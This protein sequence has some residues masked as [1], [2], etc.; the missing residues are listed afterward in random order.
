[1]ARK[2]TEVFAFTW[3]LHF[4]P[5]WEKNKNRVFPENPFYGAGRGERII[6]CMNLADS[7]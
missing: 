3:F 4:P 1:M 6:D 2:G 5:A 7:T